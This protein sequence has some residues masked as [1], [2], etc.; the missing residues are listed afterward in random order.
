MLIFIYKFQVQISKNIIFYFCPNLNKF[1][2]WKNE[3][4]KKPKPALTWKPAQ[5]AFMIWFLVN[6]FIIVSKHVLM[7]QVFNFLIIGRRQNK[8]NNVIQN[9]SKR[10]T[11]FW[12]LFKVAVFRALKTQSATN[13]W[14]VEHLGFLIVGHSL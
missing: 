7:S 3:S 6:I 5:I 11:Y 4:N 10:L 14:Q 13:F 8:C 2:C 12:S 9:K 1:K